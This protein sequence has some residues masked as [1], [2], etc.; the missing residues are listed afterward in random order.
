MVK[1]ILRSVS[2]ILAKLPDWILK[3]ICNLI[4]LIGYF[5]F[6]TKT[7]VLKSNLHHAFPSMQPK[8]I[9][10]KSRLSWC[11]CI[12]MGIIAFVS[13]HWSKDK[14]TERFSITT[15]LD[16]QLSNY[17]KNPQPTLLLYPHFTLMEAGAFIPI[18]SSAKI[19]KIGVLYRSLGNRHLEEYVK[20]TRSRFGIDLL[21]REKG[22]LGFKNR[23]Q[24]N[25]IMAM[26]FDQNAGD[27]GLLGSF[28]N[29]ICSSSP[30]LISLSKIDRIQCIL[31]YTQRKSFCRGIIKH[32]RIEFTPRSDEIIVK[33]NQFLEKL[34]KEEPVYQNNWLWI[35]NR[36]KN[37]IEPRKRFRIVSKYTQFKY[38]E[39]YPRNTRLAIRVSNWL[40][41][42]VM[43]LP[44][45]RA[46]RKARP[47]MRITLL[48]PEIHINWLLKIRIA[49][50]VIGLPPKG[51]SRFSFFYKMR[52]HYYDTYLNFTHSLR[53]D[54]EAFLTRTPQRFGLAKPG[55]KRL[56]LT[57]TYKMKSSFNNNVTH[58][59]TVW[60][61]MMNH[62]GILKPVDK[63]PLIWNPTFIRPS[64]RKAIALIPGSENNPK[65]R[66][67][68]EY[69]NALIE[70][71]IKLSPESKF[72]VLGTPKDYRSAKPI[73]FCRHYVENITGE[74]NMTQLLDV[75]S[76]LSLVIGNDTGGVHLA[77]AIGIPSIVLFGPT[78]PLRTKPI[79]D[80]KVKILQ[81]A[82]YPLTGGGPMK[83]I[84]VPQVLESFLE[85][86]SPKK[87]FRLLTN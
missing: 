11:R 39:D 81:P 52:H 58:Q 28:M 54:L 36:W 12:E 82:N 80:G 86:Y 77:N 7:R 8:E 73:G 9:N 40:G 66:W 61:A 83:E 87:K 49:D 4:G 68:V 60:Q 71:I 24:S 45:I 70:K 27:N 42:I 32:H 65:K 31:L 59:H 2:W 18:L 46:I 43:S 41:D 37:Q 38:P 10:Q 47:D 50:H 3:T 15:E 79:Y 16:A 48:A 72:V 33:S 51:W 57:D 67:P 76:K 64:H 85:L 25:E 44:H 14:I 55:I 5:F 22:F 69:W 30:L 56:L 1:S 13:S 35:H 84:L 62:F 23:L 75:L 21:A 53:S 78:N 63:T 20:N 29:R 17:I 6:P 34:L 74:T 19:S 26:A